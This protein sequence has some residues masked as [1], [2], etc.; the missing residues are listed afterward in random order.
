MRGAMAMV[1]LVRSPIEAPELAR[2]LT[3]S[4][5]ETDDVTLL[6]AWRA[7]DKGSGNRLL[8]RH[9]EAIYCFFATK[10][11]DPADLTQ[12]TF[13]A[14]VEANERFRGDSSV[15]TWIFAIARRTLF[16]HYRS[17]D[18]SRGHRGDLG[19]RSAVDLG[20]SPSKVL[21]GRDEQK[22]LVVALR[23]LPLEMQIT[24]ELHYWEAMKLQDIAVVLDIPPG[25]VKSRLARARTQLREAVVVLA[26]SPRLREDTLERLEHWA[27]AVRADLGA[28]TTEH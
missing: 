14:C 21:A 15:R 4:E 1:A 28:S 16:N 25:T 20:P 27:R 12:R 7:G 22:L 24:L 9:F 3:M 8:R 10:V 11:D 13:L 23:S 18:R 26:E 2:A 17:L 5:Q 19:Q 6:L